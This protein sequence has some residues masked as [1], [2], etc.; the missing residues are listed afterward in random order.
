MSVLQ[1]ILVVQFLVFT[2]AAGP[3]ALL[4]PKM[5]DLE[6]LAPSP[7]L[8]AHVHVSSPSIEENAGDADDDVDALTVVPVTPSSLLQGHSSSSSAVSSTTHFTQVE[9][10]TLSGS[11]TIAA[12]ST[13]SGMSSTTEA[14][15]AG[16]SY[17]DIISRLG[18]G[19]LYTCR[20]LSRRNPVLQRYA[21]K[22]HESLVLPPR[23]IFLSYNTRGV[24][25][26][27]ALK[28][29]GTH[30]SLVTRLGDYHTL[31]LALTLTLTLTLT[32]Y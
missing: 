15:S 30:K 16:F 14:S 26:S 8:T 27:L 24:F 6:S 19:V 10:T 5:R 2:C 25:H 7:S 18:H 22:F 28:R 1:V 21:R 20:V 4:A 9:P 13:M 29:R 12:S 17:E 32:L 11:S 31:V 23:D 3:I